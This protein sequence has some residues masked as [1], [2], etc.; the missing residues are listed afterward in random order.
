MCIPAFYQNNFHL[1]VLLLLLSLLT[2]IYYG[3]YDENKFLIFN[4]TYII[5][6]IILSIYGSN[7]RH[8]TLLTLISII[9]VL[10]K[11]NQKPF[12]YRIIG[13]L[14]LLSLFTAE[15]GLFNSQYRYYTIFADQTK[16]ISNHHL[17]DLVFKNND[18]GKNKIYPL[19]VIVGYILIYKTFIFMKKNN[20]KTFIT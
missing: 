1:G 19:T 8:I 20:I 4:I 2:P 11:Y 12:L 13:L 18:C 5:I 14:I 3:K 7:F 17:A 15:K 6:I 16:K 10:I 9:P